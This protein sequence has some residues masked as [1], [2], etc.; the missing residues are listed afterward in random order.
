MKNRSSRSLTVF[1]FALVICFCGCGDGSTNALVLTGNN[2]APGNVAPGSMTFNFVK[3]QTALQVPTD[4]T[5]IRFRF[6]SLPDGGGTLVQE[7]ILLVAATIKIDPVNA[8]TQSVTVTALGPEGYPVLQSTLNVVAIPGENVSVDFA[9]STTESVTQQAFTITPLNANVAAGGTLQFLASLTFSNGEQL[10]ANKVMWGATGQ[11]SADVNTG[12]V[13]AITDGTATVTATRD[14]D[15]ASANIIVGNGPVLTT[16]SVAPDGTTVGTGSQVQFSVTGV[17]QNGANFPLSDIVWSVESGTVVIGTDGLAT[18]PTNTVS[19]VRATAGSVFD[20]ATITVLNSVPSVTFEGSSTRPL[21]FPVTASDPVPVVT[22]DAGKLNFDVLDSAPLISTGATVTD[23]LPAMPTGTLSF[24][25]TGVVTDATFT[26]PMSTGVGMI[27]NPGTP[28]VTVELTNATPTN[29]AAVINGTAVAYGGTL[30]TGTIQVDLTD[31]DG[32]TAPSATRDFEITQ[33]DRI[34]VSNQS[35]NSISFFNCTDNGDVAPFRTLSGDST[36]FNG[37]RG[38]ALDFT[39]SELLVA[40]T[41][42]SSILVFAL[43]ASGDTPPLRTIS[44]SATLLSDAS[45]IVVDPVNDEIFVFTP[46]EGIS[47]FSRTA[48]G[49]T[50]PLRRISGSATNI[51]NG[52]YFALDLT[53]DEIILP[54]RNRILVFN[55]TDDGDVPPKRTLSGAATLLSGAFGVALDLSNDEIIVTNSFGV[56]VYSRTASDDTAPL[57]TISGAST[58][59]DDLYGVALNAI[60]DEILVTSFTNSRVLT[61][62]RSD[63]GDVAPL[64]NISGDAT[65]LSGPHGIFLSP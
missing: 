33:L 15:T 22:L 57:R 63:D 58:M 9:D 54:C 2:T 5:N 55:R 35:N 28:S 40:N 48:N 13:T 47:V 39:N 6:Y 17:D 21:I 51:G 25:L 60:K 8:G 19:T 20:E 64:R 12:L 34:A 41:R 62:N 1:L 18:C 4:T 59:V 65:G 36:T 37:P 11:A 46:S 42:G 52:R 45:G 10:P 7:E 50:P 32:N 16:L 30:G 56:T 24:S 31:N 44:G 23:D 3:A 26:V 43:D 29:I 27:H 53:N 14:T 38:V 49:D 61:F